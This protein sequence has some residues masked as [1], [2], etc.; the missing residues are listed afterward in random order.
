ML[1]SIR[2]VFIC[3]CFCIFV[4]F[5]GV[6]YRGPLSRAQCCNPIFSLATTFPCFLLTEILL[7]VTKINMK[8]KGPAGPKVFS[9]KS[10]PAES[11]NQSSFMFLRE[12]LLAAAVILCSIRCWS[13]A[14]V[15]I[16]WQGFYNKARDLSFLVCS[17][18]FAITGSTLQTTL[19]LQTPCYYGQPDVTDRGYIW[20]TII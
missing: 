19:A 16:S 5:Y 15:V 12:K 7:L 10:S 18:S 8:T 20:K 14:L 2:Y 6:V 17:L 11:I 9:W 13:I 3:Y 1:V 4:F